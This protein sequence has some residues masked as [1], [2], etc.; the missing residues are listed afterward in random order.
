[1]H[2]VVPGEKLAALHRPIAAA[3]IGDEASGFAHQQH[4]RRNVP[5]LKI[6]FPIAVEPPGRDPGK[7][8]RGRAIAANACHLRRDGAEDAGPL[9][10][11]ALAVERNAGRDQRFGQVPACRD[12]Q[13]LVLQP[14]PPALFGPEAFIGQRLID[15]A[16][17]DLALAVRQRLLDRDRNR[18]MGK[19]VQEV[20]CAVERIDDP[21][22]LVRIAGDFSCFLKQESPVRAGMEKLFV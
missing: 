15:Q 5:G 9:R 6:G 21:A 12:A 19:P 8:E 11:I 22:R 20:R 4:A 13:P 1:M 17:R 2:R 10:E 14:G 16:R 18:E 3:K 7:V